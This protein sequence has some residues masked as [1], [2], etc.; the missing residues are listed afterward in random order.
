M[1][2]AVIFD[3]DGVLI[4]S[5]IEY[6]K[7]SKRFLDEQGID[8]SFEDLFF[9]AGSPRSV[10]LEFLSEKMNLPKEECELIEDEFFKKFTINYAQIKKYYVDELLS[11]LKSKGITIALAS[12]SKMSNIEQVLNECN[13]RDYFTYVV[14]GEM[15]KRTKP[16]PEIYEYTCKK[17]NIE[18]DQILVVED[19][20]YGIT[21]SKAAGLKT[22]A[23]I[24][25]ILKF[26]NTLA[27][28]RVDSLKDVVD[29]IEGD[30]K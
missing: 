29:I 7:L 12:S 13:I 30:L 18:K 21:A 2:K 6:I 24:D 16:D 23:I 22:V 25:P 5:E 10:E 14:S 15:F 17:L 20:T 26:D 8:L 19:S 28:Y 27:D 4:N 11:F 9:F 3:M 1:I